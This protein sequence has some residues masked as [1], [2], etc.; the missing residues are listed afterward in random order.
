MMDSLVAIGKEA[1]PI[2][3]DY[4]WGDGTIIV[5]EILVFVFIIMK[6]LIKKE[7]R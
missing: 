6:E 7:L 4:G 2:I 1:S 3:R 5:D